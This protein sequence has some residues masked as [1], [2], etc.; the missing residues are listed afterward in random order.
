MV[1]VQRVAEAKEFGL[2]GGVRKVKKYGWHRSLPDM[3][4]H[5]FSAHRAMLNKTPDLVDL[6]PKMPPVYDQGQLGSCTANASGAAFEYDQIKQGIP[7]WTPSRLMIYYLERLMEGT[8]GEDAGAQ[9]R[10]ALKVLSKYGVCPESHWPYNVDK[11]KMKPDVQDFKIASM[12]QALRYASVNQTQADFE[13]VLASGYPIIGGFTVYSGFESAEAEKTGIV[14]MPKPKERNQ[15]GHAILIVGYDRPKQQFIVRNSWGASWG[16]KGY[17]KI[18]Y[19]YF[20]NPKLADDFWVLYSVEDGD[21]V[22]GE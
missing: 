3:R 8:V 15:G 14:P 1:F 19:A 18:P 4:D 22:D 17:F 21:S 6:S 12:N 7:A 5:M 13:A 9:I 16:L 2:D 20:L 10:D 11:F